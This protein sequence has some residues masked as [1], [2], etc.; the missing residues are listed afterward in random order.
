MRL[1]THYLTIYQSLDETVLPSRYRRSIF[2]DLDDD[3]DSDE[4]S[5]GSDDEGVELE[6]MDVDVDEVS[7]WESEKENA[8]PVDEAED[9]GTS[10][11]A[12][13]FELERSL[14]QEAY[15]I[16]SEDNLKLEFDIETEEEISCT[17]PTDLEAHLCKVVEFTEWSRS[18]A[19]ILI[20][21]CEVPGRMVALCLLSFTG[22]GARI[23][24]DMRQL[25]ID[26]VQSVFE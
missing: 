11:V 23:D 18:L 5:D 10:R 14:A 16:R 2:E 1:K 17:I 15:Y 21:D 7:E 9:S 13:T 6:D 12:Y 20:E 19:W 4:D 24:E 25:F 26:W 22:R 8:V 3:S